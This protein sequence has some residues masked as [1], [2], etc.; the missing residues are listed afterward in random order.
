LQEWGT[1]RKGI[2]EPN[3]W[4]CI[5][6]GVQISFDLLDDIVIDAPEGHARTGLHA[7]QFFRTQHQQ[8]EH[9]RLQRGHR[10]S[11]QQKDQT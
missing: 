7:T 1:W 8:A 6:L 5:E 10:V 3:S 4:Q 11:D 9:S 2:E